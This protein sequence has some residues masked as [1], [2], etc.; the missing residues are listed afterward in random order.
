MYHAAEVPGKGEDALGGGWTPPQ[1]FRYITVFWEVSTLNRW[2]RTFAVDQY[3]N[4]I[5][6]IFFYEYNPVFYSQN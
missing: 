1:R 5:I 4:S 2:Y 6:L 3:A